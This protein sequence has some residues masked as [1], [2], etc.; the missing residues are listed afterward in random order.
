MLG[1]GGQEF[2]R[3]VQLAAGFQLAD[4]AGI[5]VEV[6]RARRLR[7]PTAPGSGRN[8]RPAPC[9]ATSSVMAASSAS[10]C[11]GVDLA[12]ALRAARAGFSDSLRGRRCRRP[13]EL[14]IASVSMRPPLR[15]Y[16]M[17]PSCVTPRLAPSPTTLAR[18]SPPLTR[19]ASLARSPTSSLVWRGGLDVGADAAE[20]E[21]IG[22]GLQQRVDQ[23]GGRQAC[24]R[25]C[26]SAPSPR[27]ES[28]IS[29]SVRAKTPPPL[30]IR[31]LL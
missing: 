5:G 25:R 9:A 3:A 31:L 20:P 10:R 22:L 26:R 18:T 6:A 17:R 28:G 4:E 19:T 24:R 16:S 2:H 11:V 29:F 8:C 23:L 15:A 12:A 27:G 14:S 13:A 30:P 21:Q 1:V 7:P